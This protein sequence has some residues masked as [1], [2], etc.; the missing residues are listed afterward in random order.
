[1]EQP[2]A[3]GG[4]LT[5]EDRNRPILKKTEDN[6][7]GSS[8]NTKD[9]PI[10]LAEESE[11]KNAGGFAR[12]KQV[13]TGAREGSNVQCDIKDNEKEQPLEEQDLEDT[14]DK[15]APKKVMDG[16]SISSNNI[17]DARNKVEM[18]SNNELKNLIKEEKDCESSETFESVVNNCKSSMDEGKLTEIKNSSKKISQKSNK[19]PGKDLI[20]DVENRKTRT[21]TCLTKRVSD[22][23]KNDITK[24]T[25]ES[26]ETL[27][28]SL[29]TKDTVSVKLQNAKTKTTIPCSNTSNELA[30]DKQKDEDQIDNTSAIGDLSNDESD[31]ESD[32][33]PSFTR[34]AANDPNFAVVYSFLIV[35][36][37]LLNIP[38]CTLQQ[39]E[40][41]LD[42]CNDF[43]L[44]AGMNSN[45]LYFPF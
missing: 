12:S 16:C 36:G 4:V 42:N 9:V 8:Q 44:E 43:A 10:S 28:L 20:K 7:S 34:R 26:K 17:D 37:E 39:L 29:S 18:S 32:E 15:E 41:S 3:V 6:V 38:E 19:N 22:D 25:D 13:V 24:S 1:M 33:Y 21:A 23:V 27:I 40:D 14:E 2:K 11:S 35:F 31:K 30:E 45:I 5:L